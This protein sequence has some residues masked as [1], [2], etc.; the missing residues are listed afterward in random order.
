M[1]YTSI[2]YITDKRDRPESFFFSLSRRR[3]RMRVINASKQIKIVVNFGIY[4]LCYCSFF[5]S[6]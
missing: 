4:F 5:S 3:D 6:Y 1:H 2:K